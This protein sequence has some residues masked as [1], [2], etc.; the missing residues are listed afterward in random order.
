MAWLHLLY[1]RMIEYITQKMHRF[2][3]EDRHRRKKQ[4]A[5]VAVVSSHIIGLLLFIFFFRG[6]IFSIDALIVVK[7]LLSFYYISFIYTLVLRCGH[8]YFQWLSLI[9]FDIYY[10]VIDFL[11]MLKQRFKDYVVVPTGNFLVKCGRLIERVFN[12]ILDIISKVWKK[13]C[14]LF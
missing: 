11:K 2:F 7:L 4:L 1:F 9:P 13:K 8:I 5:F 14:S 6:F 3:R 10:D 12:K